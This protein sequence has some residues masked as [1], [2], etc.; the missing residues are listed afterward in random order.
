MNMRLSRSLLA[1][2]ATL[3]LSLACFKVDD[4]LNQPCTVDRDC[5]SSALVCIANVCREGSD[6]QVR[7]V[8]AA[9]GVDAVDLYLAGSEEPIVANLGFKNVSPWIR[10]PSDELSLEFRAAGAAASEQALFTTENTTISSE[11]ST[12]LIFAGLKDDSQDDS[13][14]V[15]PIVESWGGSLADRARV[16]LVHAG[17]DSPDFLVDGLEGAAFSLAR[18]EDSAAAGT[19]ISTSGDERIQLFE[20]DELSTAFSLPPLSEGSEVLL[21]AT[22]LRSSLAREQEGFSLLAI[23]EEGLL[24]RVLQDPQIFTLHGARDAGSLENC[25][26]GFEVAT[27]FEYGEIQSTFLSPGEYTFELYEYP[28]GCNTTVLNPRGNIAPALDAGERYLILITGELT[29]D[30][31]EPSIQVASFVDR[32]APNSPEETLIRFVHGASFTQIFVGNE[33]EPGFITEEN[34]YT[35]PIA[36]RQESRENTLEP[37]PY[38]LGIADANGTPTPTPPLSVIVNFDIDASAGSR[39]WGIVAG[40]PL[41]DAQDLDKPIQLMLVDTSTDEWTVQLVDP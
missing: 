29:P 36:W 7:L 34:V 4:P 11:N 23:G 12:T 14:R 31:E 35:D 24:Q 27:N 1:L 39:Q 21:V 19:P 6:A 2:L 38:A 30:D 33:T 20:G 40:D 8:H 16:R 18:Y 15:L 37:G 32:F 3:F 10:V 28:S 26:N 41:V 17:A 9:S 5:I 22:G 25:T 13:L